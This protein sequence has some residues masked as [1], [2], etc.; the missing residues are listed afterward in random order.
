MMDDGWF[1]KPGL[2]GKCGGL[3]EV[4]I[5]EVRAMAEEVEPLAIGYP[6]EVFHWISAE[7]TVEE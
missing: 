5:V 1:G 7:F 3:P 6:D 2:G 4:D